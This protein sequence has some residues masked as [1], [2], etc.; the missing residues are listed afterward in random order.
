MESQAHMHCRI[1]IKEPIDQ[2]W[3]DW[4]EGLQIKR[5]GTGTTTLEGELRDQAAL[6]GVLFTIRQLG[7]TLLS[8]ETDEAHPPE[9]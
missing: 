1:C 7:L 4:F 9:K 6:Y 8:C 3:Q 2:S 5:E